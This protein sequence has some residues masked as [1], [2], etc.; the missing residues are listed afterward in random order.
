MIWYEPQ[1]DKK[2]CIKCANKTNI[3]WQSAK[4]VAEEDG[5]EYTHWTEKPIC[6][7]CLNGNKLPPADPSSRSNCK[8][9]QD[10]SK[11]HCYTSSRINTTLS[12]LMQT[13]QQSSYSTGVKAVVKAK[14]KKKCCHTIRWQNKRL[15]LVCVWGTPEVRWAAALQRASS[16]ELELKR[17]PFSSL[18]RS[19]AASHTHEYCSFILKI[20][21]FFSPSGK[22]AHTYSVQMSQSRSKKKYKLSRKTKKKESAVRHRHWLLI[23]PPDTIWVWTREERHMETEGRQGPSSAWW[24]RFAE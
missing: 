4:S 11:T 22:H 7:S 9:D 23:F 13:T 19:A 20:S 5:G 15:T 8:H 24:M 1:W 2:S 6:R 14:K 21:S 3:H 12:T 16:G 18:F 17:Q 10:P